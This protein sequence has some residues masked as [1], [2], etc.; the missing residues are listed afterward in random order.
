MSTNDH[1]F[2]RVL[3]WEAGWAREFGLSNYNALAA[4]TSNIADMYGLSN[5]GVGRIRVGTKANF[6]LFDDDPLSNVGHVQLV[7]LGQQL[8]LKPAQF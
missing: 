7:A 4:V 5:T 2:S 8:A 3:R 1:A 6:V